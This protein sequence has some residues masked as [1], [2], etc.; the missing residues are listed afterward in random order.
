M[1]SQVAGTWAKIYNLGQRVLV[2][3]SF[4]SEFEYLYFTSRC[5][6]LWDQGI[7]NLELQ[8]EAHEKLFQLC[9]QMH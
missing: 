8:V 3:N 1:I 2:C 6:H 7:Q 9:R 4:W 5:V